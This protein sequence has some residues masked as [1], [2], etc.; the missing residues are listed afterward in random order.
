[1]SLFEVVVSVVI[2]TMVGLR[3]QSAVVVTGVVVV[4]GCG[5]DW[6]LL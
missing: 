6:L 2:A 3:L 4:T 5:C 1:M